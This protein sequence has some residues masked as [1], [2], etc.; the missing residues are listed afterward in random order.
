MRS[1][2]KPVSCIPCAKRKVRCDRLQPC[3]HC[4]RRPQDDCLYPAPSPLPPDGDQ[5][6][7]TRR[8]ETLER[9]IRSL[10]G[11][12][13]EAAQSG[14]SS[15]PIVKE[16]Q[17]GYQE[18]HYKLTSPFH[19]ESLNVQTSRSP[20]AGVSMEQ[21]AGLVV[22]DEEVTYIETPMWYSWSGAHQTYRGPLGS[23]TPENPQLASRT[24]SSHC[25][26]TIL[27]PA[28]LPERDSLLARHPLAAHV[29]LLWRRY[30]KNVHPL[31]NIFFSWEIETIIQ[32]SCKDASGLSNGERALVFSI[33]FVASLSIQ[34]DEF[35]TLLGDEKLRVLNRFQRGVEDALFLAEFATTSDRLVLQAFMLYLVAM[36]GRARPA[37]LFSLMGIA[38]RIAE[39]MGLQRDGDLLGLSVLRSEER[40]RIWWYLQ[41]MEI[42]TARLVG[43]VA[44]NLY[45]SWDT[46]PPANLEDSDLYPGIKALPVERGGLTGMS[47]CLWRSRILQTQR[48]R[49]RSGEEREGLAWIL[50]PHVTL[51]DKDARID[52]IEKILGERFLQHCE[53]LNP[54]HTYIHIGIREF[55]LACRRT[56]RQ[57]ALI[58]AKISEMSR[59]QRDDLLGICTKVLEYYVLSQTT[60]SLQGFQWHNETNFDWVAVVYVI[61]EAHHRL[62]DHN[63]AA[64]LWDSIRK[65][66]AIHP[67]LKRAVHR[68]EV[69]SV[70]RLTLAAW[71]KHNA[72]IQQERLGNGSAEHEIPQWIVEISENF[73][74]PHIDS[75]NA[76]PIVPADFDFD[77]F[78]WSNW[79]ESYL[80]TGLYGTTE[81]VATTV[82]RP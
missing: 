19:A 60:E 41:Y 37:A 14:E 38:T 46:K 16:T 1:G 39:R 7:Y 3:C 15:S 76:S 9:Y 58:N 47:Y 12:P 31:A 55:L 57:P 51:A 6:D 23:P 35:I 13:Q 82:Q 78:D 65:V 68:A 45:G 30:L 70:A 36:Q 4:K 43:T 21:A 11:D 10:G 26:P 48:E 59:S 40:R 73:N 2:K 62:D 44:M 49:R 18:D 29:T 56:V 24:L 27:D 74:L 71:Q 50:S 32:K 5:E 22:H 25:F 52:I 80:N 69:T 81:Q 42:A 77:M 33:C 63:A 53:L 67:E 28:S 54:L 8:I 66:Y 79:E 17:R 72:N 20:A 34:Q 75:T 64:D 61:L